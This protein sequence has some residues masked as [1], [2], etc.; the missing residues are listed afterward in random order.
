MEGFQQSFDSTLVDEA[1]RAVIILNNPEPASRVFYSRVET[2]KAGLAYRAGN[3][4]K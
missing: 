3:L 1:F 2:T 4:T